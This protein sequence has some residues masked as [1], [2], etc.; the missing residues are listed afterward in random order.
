[1]QRSLLCSAIVYAAMASFFGLSTPSVAV[2]IS[3]P[4][5]FTPSTNA[6]LAG[7]L[8]VTTDVP[9]RVSVSVSDGTDAWERNFY[10]YATSNSV[11]L[12]GFKPGRTNIIQLTAYD[13]NRNADTAT[14]LLTFVTA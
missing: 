4:P 8:Q 3:S 9:A 7:V 1:M 5:T 14:D 11:P 6:P 2:T 13:E 12:Y 10:D